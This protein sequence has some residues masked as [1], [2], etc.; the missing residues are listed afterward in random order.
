[1]RVILQ[2]D[3]FAPPVQHVLLVALINHALEERHRLDV[4]R[5]DSAV[6]AWLREQSSELRAEIE[7]ALDSSAHDEA[8]EP[9]HTVV[10]V[11]TLAGSDFE[12]T[13]IRL[14]LGQAQQFLG[15]PFVVLLE[16]FVSDHSF[17]TKMMSDEERRFFNQRVER[18][19]VR[20][21][22]GGG[23]GSM[24]RRVATI[25]NNAA[26]RHRL[27]VLFDSDAMQPGQPSRQSAEL[28]DAAKR[29]PHHQ[30]RRRYMES[31]LPRQALQ[32]WAGS[33]TNVRTRKDRLERFRAFVE[34]TEPQRH[35]YNM[36]TGFEG[37]TS[38]TDGTAGTLYDG[39]AEDTTRTLSHG[40]GSDIGTL[41]QTDMVSERD[42]RS[43]PGWEELRPVI[44]ELLA[45][46]R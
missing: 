8:R 7:L 23:L 42:L 29:L 30:L 4:D 40:F 37:D 33:V 1:M 32:A 20:I 24:T 38:R 43:D 12:R 2:P 26:E 41:F 14:H 15:E 36:K 6:V 39:V 27:W 3:L 18:G 44:C 19:F 35:H 21:E 25:G 16:D 9:S 45:R 22:H 10:E 17:I 11:T 34:L 46:V 31:Y 5:Q 28:R 13:P